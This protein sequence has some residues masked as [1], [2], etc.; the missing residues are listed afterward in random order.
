MEEKYIIFEPY[1]C[2]LSNVLMSFELAFSLAHITNRTLILPSKFW[3][4]QIDYGKR[5]ENWTD[6]WDILDLNS[7]K[8]EI[9]II[10]LYEYEPIKNNIEQATSHDWYFTEYVTHYISDYYH[11]TNRHEE[12]RCWDMINNT[13]CFV[14]GIS[15]TDDYE[16]FTKGR[17][18]INVDRPEKYITFKNNLFGHFWYQVYAGDKE[19]RNELKRKINKCIGYKRSYY[20]IV[21]RIFKTKDFNAVHIRSGEPTH[22]FPATSLGDITGLY[23]GDHIHNAVKRLIPNDKPLYLANDLKDKTILNQLRSDYDCISI[24]DLS[25]DLSEM[26][27]AIVEQIICVKADYY[28]GTYAGTYSKRINIMRGI[29]GKQTSDYMGLNYIVDNEQEHFGVSYPWNENGMQHWPWHW[30]SYPQWNFE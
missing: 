24:E 17:Y 28:V 27:K 7:V 19:K 14:N 9:K 29:E 13:S 18:V 25:T 11:F 30:S 22:R 1:R 3:W 4:E 16:M 21:D 10:D 5:K 20:D 2:G 26:E 6:I 15:D 8:Q 23:S 12:N